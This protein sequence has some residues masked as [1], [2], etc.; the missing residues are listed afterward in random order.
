MIP[1]GVEWDLYE[2]KTQTHAL[3]IQ[4]NG[5]NTLQYI[6]F[7]SVAIITGQFEHPIIFI[8][9]MAGAFRKGLDCYSD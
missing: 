6:I 2:D 9:Q 4:T 1:P 8:V 7:Y 3:H 5:I